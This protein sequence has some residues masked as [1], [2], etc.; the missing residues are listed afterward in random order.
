[1]GMVLDISVVLIM[2]AFAGTGARR[3]LVMTL[4]KIVAFVGGLIGAHVG[5]TC[6]KGVIA[7]KLVLP[8]LSER[9]SGSGYNPSAEILN[10]VGEAGMQL[11]QELIRIMES[12]GIPGFSLSGIWGGLIDGL[13]GTGT[14]ILDTAKNVVAVRI[15]YV[16]VFIILFLAIQLAALIVFSSIDGLRHLP[17]LGTVNRLGGGAA[18]CLMGLGVVWILMM[19]IPMIFPKTALPGAP[20]S[21]EVLAGTRAAGKLYGILRGILP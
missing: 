20:F 14:N 19:V 13:T 8:W 1:M 17:L 7:S 3:G 16:A 15:S 10:G 6:L 11:E 4:E 2:L 12:A 9:I 5:A 18:G 21:P